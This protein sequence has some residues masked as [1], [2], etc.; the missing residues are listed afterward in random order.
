MRRTIFFALTL[1]A[2]LPF[3][4]CSGNQTEQANTNAARSPAATPATANAAPTASPSPQV[5]TASVVETSLD[6]GGAGEANV[7]LDIA[8]GYHVNANPASDKFYVA[9][10]VKAQAQEGITPG[11]P[12]YPK[13]LTRKLGF[14]DKPLAVYEG[15]VV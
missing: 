5:V 14:S 8:E 4:A 9:T 10:E 7:T 3:C 15:R 2:T 6:A 1:C 13:A 11:K 12:V